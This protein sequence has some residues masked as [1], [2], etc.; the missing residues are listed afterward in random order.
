MSKKNA[1]ETLNDAASVHSSLRKG[2]SKIWYQKGDG[3][4]W[5]RTALLGLPNSLLER[6]DLTSTHIL[7][8]EVAES[9]PERIFALLQGEVWSPRGEARDLISSKGLRHTSMM[10]GDVVEIGGRILAVAVM[11]FEPIWEDAT[12]SS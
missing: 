7:L 1:Y 12:P 6:P 4:G 8:G 10:V 2:G 3:P 11:G 9:D 5:I